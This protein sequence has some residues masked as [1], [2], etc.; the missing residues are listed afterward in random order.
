MNKIGLS[1]VRKKMV[2]PM[3]PRKSPVMIPSMPISPDDEKER[4]C[5]H[6]DG[7]FNF[8][9]LN[10]MPAI[11]LDDEADD[12]NPALGMSLSEMQATNLL[13][14]MIDVKKSQVKKEKDLDKS[15]VEQVE[16]A[17][18]RHMMGNSY[19]A[20]LC[21]KKVNRIKQER[22]RVN[23]AI[24][25][26]EMKVINLESD[27]EEARAMAASQRKG[28]DNPEA[29]EVNVDIDEHGNYEQEIK[30]ILSMSR[31]RISIDTEEEEE[32]DD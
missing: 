13:E 32:E 3:S 19:G 5:S 29:F 25:V 18:A 26:M 17:T 31:T 4:S 7:S 10:G 15:I 30:E 9:Y 2:L 22:E 8:Q 12:N 14:K 1:P 27:L 16:L 6:L 11:D 28:A 21:M 24:N 20:G 23:S